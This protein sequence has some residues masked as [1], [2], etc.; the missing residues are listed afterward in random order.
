MEFR[1]TPPPRRRLPALRLRPVQRRSRWGWLAA[2]V[3]VVGLG[4]LDVYAGGVGDV[5]DVETDRRHVTERHV[6]LHAARFE[7]LAEC[8]EVLHLEADVI[9]R[10]ALGA[11]V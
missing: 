5:G 7:L 10:P 11:D 3:L 1:K 2:S 9:D 4:Q 8:L 6:E